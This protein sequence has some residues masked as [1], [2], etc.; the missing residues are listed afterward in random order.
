[1]SG[2]VNNQKKTTRNLTPKGFDEGGSGYYLALPSDINVWLFPNTINYTLKFNNNDF[3]V[4]DSLNGFC[5][6][7]LVI[8]SDNALINGE[9]F[10]TKF[11]YTYGEVAV[12][13]FA[14]FNLYKYD[15]NSW[16]LTVIPQMNKQI[17]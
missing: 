2:N 15:S 13:I 16:I 7:N 10:S 1:M 12:V 4:G 6:G 8:S 9:N 17:I 3:K 11:Q 14:S 5:G